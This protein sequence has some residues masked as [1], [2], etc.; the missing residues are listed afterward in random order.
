MRLALLTFQKKNLKEI[1]TQQKGPN[2]HFHHRCKSKQ[3][4]RM[5]TVWLHSFEQDI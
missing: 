3:I 5:H 1:G 2:V 4:C